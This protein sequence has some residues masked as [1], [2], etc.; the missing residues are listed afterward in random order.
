M[1]TVAAGPRDPRNRHRPAQRTARPWTAFLRGL[2]ARGVRLVTADAHGGLKTAIG[3]VLDGATWQRRRTHF[4]RACA[5]RSHDPPRRWS[6]RWYARYSLRSAP[7]TPGVSSVTSSPSSRGQVGP[8]R[9]AAGRRR[10]RRARVHRVP[11]VK[12]R[13]PGLG[14]ADRPVGRRI[15]VAVAVSA[16]RH[17]AST[18][19]APGSGPPAR[20]FCM[21]VSTR[22]H[23]ANRTIPTHVA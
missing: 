17:G 13:P 12:G 15:A 23:P 16:T 21:A 20:P 2:V 5:P 8:C 18:A 4:M 11:Q 7:R 19:T 10:T 6:P 3:A 22:S 14:G 9:A 1:R